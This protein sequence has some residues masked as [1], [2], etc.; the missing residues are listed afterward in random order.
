M[1]NL[2][3]FLPIIPGLAA[4]CAL[5]PWVCFGDVLISTNGERFVGKVAQETTNT[6]VFESETVGRLVIARD[7][8]REI[9]RT[10]PSPPS[11][12]NRVTTATIPITATTTNTAWRPPGVGKDGADW[13]HLKSDEWLKGRLNYV[14]DK[15]VQ[16][17]SDELEDL[18]LKLKDV[19]DLYPGKPM[20]TKFDGR[21]QVFGTVTISNG[22][23]E[24]IG[25]EQVTLPRDQLTGIT[26]GGDREINFWSFKANVGVNFQNGNTK[27]T[28][29]NTS[30]E[31]AR[32]TPATQFIITYLGNYSELNGEESAN[33]HRVN[34]SYD[35]RLSRHWFVRPLQ[36][37]WYRDQLANISHRLTAGVGVGYYIFDSDTLE[38][39]VAAGPG[40]QYTRFETVEP[41]ADESAST[42]AGIAQTTF[43]ADITRRL[44]FYQTI[45]AT[46]ASEEAGLYSHHFVTTLEFEIKRSLNLDVSF[47]WDYLQNPQAE[48]SGVV[49]QH[50]DLRFITSIGVKF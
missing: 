7:R 2:R 22:L 9:Q 4:A 19:R 11:G 45:N 14:Q 31:L 37:E 34:L 18:T 29:V 17:E 6:V 8:I 46:L 15:K 43:K 26:P 1:R 44:T 48:S 30:A 49:P 42:P 21:D 35:V 20:F 50:S 39:K 23:V 13:V 16:F 33:N 40:Y 10:T 5:F 3:T 47:V 32:R 36:V 12:T 25:P 24:V 41:G 38:W 28:T 27:Q